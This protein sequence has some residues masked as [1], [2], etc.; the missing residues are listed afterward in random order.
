MTRSA[1]FALAALAAAASLAFGNAQAGAVIVKDNT[2]VNVIPGL[3]GFSTTGAMMSGLSITASFSGGLTETLSWATTGASS[4]GVTG[5]GWGLSVSGDTFAALWNFSMTS[6]LGQ[7]MS[8]IIDGTNALTVLDTTNPAPGT[9]DS[10]NGADFTFTDASI[11]ATATYSSVVAIS[12]N[13]AVGDLYQVL[14]V[15]FG[16][17]G[18]RTGFTFRQDTDNDSRFRDGGNVPEPASLAL[19]GLALAVAGASAR[20]ARKS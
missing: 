18:P 10:A 4:G 11:N 14:S 7:I 19:V 20:R 5:S 3:T 8:L 12:P 16:N 15:N 1:R 6:N 17:G 2:N 13:A 9:A